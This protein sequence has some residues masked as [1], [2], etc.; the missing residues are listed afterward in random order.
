MDSFIPSP[1]LAAS[2]SAFFNGAELEF[3]FASYRLA[4]EVSALNEDRVIRENGAAFNPRPARIAAIL[5]KEGKIRDANTIAA[6]FLACGEPSKISGLQ[7]ADHI[8]SLSKQ[9]QHII[10]NGAAVHNTSA[11]ALTIAYAIILD[12]IRHL[13]MTNM[14]HAEQLAGLRKYGALISSSKSDLTP[15]LVKASSILESRCAE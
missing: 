10:K 13:H 7:I 6:A 12:G 11:E 14:T 1:A 8:L 5:I 2:L 9:A 4:C 3:L 15:Y